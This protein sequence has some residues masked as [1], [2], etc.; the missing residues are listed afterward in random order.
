MP[1]FDVVSEVDIHELRNAV[2]QSNR[3]INNRFDLKGSSAKFELDQKQVKI[4]ADAEFQ[5][6][7]L[8]DILITKLIKRSIDPKCVDAAEVQAYGKVVHLMIAIREGIEGD[9]ARKII[10][11]IKANKLK[12][13]TAIQGEKL[14]V[15][16]KKRDDLQQV[17]ALIKQESL[18]WPLQYNNFRD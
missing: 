2:D 16:G 17:I 14:R 5:A 4:T 12:V 1:S 7:Q 10:K 8:K 9:L 18:E 13:Q 15:T 3:E 11:L 6:N